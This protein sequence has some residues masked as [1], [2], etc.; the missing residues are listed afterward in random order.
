MGYFSFSLKKIYGDDTV[1]VKA[2]ID[3]VKDTLS[4]VYTWYHE[5]YNSS[6]DPSLSQSGS[7]SMVANDMETNETEYDI[8]SEWKQLNQSGNHGSMTEVDKYL[9]SSIEDEIQGRKFE[10]LD[11]WRSNAVK[12][13]VLSQVA[14]DI[15]A[16]HV[17]SVASESAFSTGG[18]ILDSFR[19]CLRPNT[20][21][22]LICTQNWIRSGQIP[23]DLQ[24]EM[25]E[26]EEYDQIDADLFEKGVSALSLDD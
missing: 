6:K 5:K 15:L 3:R 18:R 24:A 19:S 1:K 16:I 11:W 23:I 20:I 26:V 22:A 4:R 9:N 8:A 17:T 25:K 7:A 12:Y 2:V 14:R 21:E 13:P 10:I